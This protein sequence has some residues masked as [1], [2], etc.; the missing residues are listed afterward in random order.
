MGDDKGLAWDLLV[1]LRKELIELQ[2]IRAQVIGFK[3]TF[4]SAGVA[5]IAANLEKL[6]I[7]LFVIPALAAIFFDLLIHS[8]SFSIKRT[9]SYCRWHLE[10]VLREH[11]G[12]PTERP[13]WEEWMIGEDAGKNVSFWG[14]LGI[15]FLAIAPAVFALF[16]PFRLVLSVPLLGCIMALLAYDIVALYKPRRF[17][18][19]R[20][21]N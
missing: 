6:P 7:L 9:G 21:T 17:T 3:I 16:A 10:P 13:L 14:N 5:L 20:K 1:E 8:Y 4:V 12:F 11:R 19:R 2:K 15:T 18:K